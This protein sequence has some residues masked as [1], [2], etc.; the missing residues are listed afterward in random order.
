VE[1]LARVLAPGAVVDF[2]KGC[3][4]SAFFIA[5]EPPS[6]AFLAQRLSS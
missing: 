6:L 2:S 3:H 1:A 5:Q 4:T